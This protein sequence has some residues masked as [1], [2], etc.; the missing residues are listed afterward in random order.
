M[1]MGWDDLLMAGAA[2]LP[3]IISGVAQADVSAETAKYARDNNERIKKLIDAIQ[4]PENVDFSQFKP[5]DFK[6]AAQYNPQV[7]KFVQERA[8]QLIENNSAEAQQGL[9]AQRQVLQQMQDRAKSGTDPLT[10]IARQRALTD[11]SQ[12]ASSN[13]ASIQDQMARRGVG[14]DSGMALAAKLAAGGDAANRMAQA[15]QQAAMDKYNAMGQAQSQAANLGGQMYNTQ[16]DLATKNAGLINAYNERMANNQNAY[17]QYA[18][19]V[20]NQ[21]QQYNVGNTNQAAT[22]NTQQANTT[23]WNKLAQ[24]QQQGQQAFGN[25]VQKTGLQTGNINQAT[26]N[27]QTAAQGTN[28][29]YQGFG[30]A[31]SKAV[32]T[33]DQLSKKKYQNPYGGY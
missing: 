15:G 12:F 2:T 20:Q 30:D 7:A 26:Q 4:N 25:Q 18:S 31:A 17:G 3:Q 8:P 24:Q 19:G 1:V 10:E 9:A 32:M 29:M 23:G 11:A 28:N 14:M 22:A 5:Q 27:A 16:M 6:V 13:Q 33:A 21:G